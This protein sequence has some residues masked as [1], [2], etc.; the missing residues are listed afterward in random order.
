M[1]PPVAHA[2]SI[3]P[4]VAWLVDDGDSGRVLGF[5]VAV[6]I[7]AIAT[8]QQ[9]GTGGIHVLRANELAAFCNFFAYNAPCNL[10]PIVPILSDIL[11]GSSGDDLRLH[12]RLV[13]QLTD[14]PRHLV[15]L[16]R[17]AEAF[18]CISLFS[19]WF[20]SPTLPALSVSNKPAVPSKCCKPTG[21]KSCKSP[22]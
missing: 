15:C 7:G 2:R 14:S 3:A 22:L 13:N 1:I 5:L 6:I 4:L 18:R 20:V 10:S 21:P 8:A 17:A 9:R 16:F 19:V 11:P 12:P